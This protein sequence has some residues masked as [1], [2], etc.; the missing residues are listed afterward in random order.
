MNEAS[1]QRYNELQNGLD[2]VRSRKRDMPLV[3]IISLMTT[4]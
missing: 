3:V 1:C 4:R 2:T